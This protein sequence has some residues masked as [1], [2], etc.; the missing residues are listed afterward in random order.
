MMGRT[1][2]SMADSLL[3]SRHFEE[4]AEALEEVQRQL[5]GQVEDLEEKSD[6]LRKQQL[7]ESEAKSKL[8]EETSRLTAENMVCV[9]KSVGVLHLSPRK[10]RTNFTFLPGL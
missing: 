9:D 8:R 5:Q 3:F 6:N 10:S 1:F 4:K 2:L 7:M